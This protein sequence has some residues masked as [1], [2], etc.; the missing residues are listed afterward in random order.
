MTESDPVIRV[1]VELAASAE[2]VFQAW[3][4]P[5]Q[6]RQWWGGWA[7][8]TAP[9]MLFEP[10]VGGTW[11]FAMAFDGRTSWVTGIVTEL[12]PGRRLRFTFAWEGGEAL[13]TPVLLEFQGLEGGG[14]RLRLTHDQSTGGSA[15]AEG[16]NWS[17]GC[18]ADH[19]G[20]QLEPSSVNPRSNPSGSDRAPR[21]G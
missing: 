5:D 2:R 6:V 17:L 12:D 3:T 1:S 16:W 13:P 19:L 10:R 4:D 9:D 7:L 8:D 20:G 15:C 14:S 21:L 18:L 11:R